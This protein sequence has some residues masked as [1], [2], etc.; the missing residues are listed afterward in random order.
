MKLEKIVPL[1][2]LVSSIAVVITLIYLTIQT[3]QT[4]DALL[5]SSRQA[6]L[7]TDVTL[8]AALVQNPEVMENRINGDRINGDRPPLFQVQ[9]V[10]PNTWTAQP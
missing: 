8:I 1:A 4:H 3:Q 7:A 9:T 10:E 6:T 5:A 2:E